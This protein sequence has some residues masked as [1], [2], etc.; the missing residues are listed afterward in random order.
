MS[1]QDKTIVRTAVDLE[2]KYNLGK[3]VGLSA[4]VE[5]NSE[6]LFK[7]ENELNDFAEQTT[8]SLENMEEEI[9]GKVSTW[10]YSGIPSLSNIPASEWTTAEEKNKHI[11]D[12]YYDQA[13]GYCYRFQIA[14][15]NYSWVQVRDSKITEVLAIANAAQD[16]AD[17]K[18]RIFVRQPTTPYDNGD[19]WVGGANGDIKVCQVSRETGSYQANDWIIASKYT[20]N[21]VANAI[22]DE[23]GGTTTTV[24]HGQVVTQMAEYTKFTDLATG[25]STTIAGENITT[26]SIKSNNYVQGVSGTSI[27]LL[28]GTIDSKNLK[29]LS[30]GNLEIAGYIKTDHGILTNLQYNCYPSQLGQT[31]SFYSGMSIE[32]TA[33]ELNVYIPNNFEILSA[34]VRVNLNKTQNMFMSIDGEDV[35]N[36][37]KVHNIRLYKLRNGDT[38][39]NSYMGVFDYDDSNLVEIPGAFGSSGYSA[40]TINEGYFNSIDIKS[41]LSVNGTTK[42]VIKTADP[43]LNIETLAGITAASQQTQIAYATIDIIGYMSN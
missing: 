37:G 28:N 34:I 10:Y 39:I 38:M 27:N 36:Y 1:L 2:K 35:I 17:H 14:S 31:E 42:L 21:T 12:L 33:L 16:T 22:V 3:L 25:G 30:N 11:G 43:L 41:N 19:L 20:D 18:R 15:G 29:V 5:T 8:R 32:K 7:V 40:P 24:L 23:L 9:D 6:Q 26:G 13:T 4:N